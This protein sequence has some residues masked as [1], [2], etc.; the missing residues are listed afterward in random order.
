MY[1]TKAVVMK[2]MPALSEPRQKPRSQ[3]GNLKKRPTATPIICQR[4][5][6]TMLLPNNVLIQI[7]FFFVAADVSWFGIGSTSVSPKGNLRRAQRF[8]PIQDFA[9]S[10]GALGHQTGT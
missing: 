5:L 3:G 6:K 8:Q 4:S 2:K 1:V 7:E 9:G 10:Q